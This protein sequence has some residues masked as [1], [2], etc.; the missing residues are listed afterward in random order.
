[1]IATFKPETFYHVAVPSVSVRLGLSAFSLVFISSDGWRDLAVGTPGDTRFAYDPRMADIYSRY[2]A[3]HHARNVG[4]M[5]VRHTTTASGIGRFAVIRETCKCLEHTKPDNPKTE[6][7][8]DEQMSVAKVFKLARIVFDISNDD[9]YY[10]SKILAALV[11][12]IIAAGPDGCKRET[13]YSAWLKVG[14]NERSFSL[15]IGL[16]KRYGVLREHSGVYHYLVAK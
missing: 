2:G 12:A 1:M 7:T 3:I 6:V 15:S 11:D 4:G 9:L 5:A 14:G 13:L 10:I 8:R 16:L